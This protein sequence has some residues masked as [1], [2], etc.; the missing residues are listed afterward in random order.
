MGGWKLI[1]QAT[2]GE[3][4]K[5]RWTWH[6][7]TVWNNVGLWWKYCFWALDEHKVV[8]FCSSANFKLDCKK[9]YL[10]VEA[11][12]HF[13]VK[14]RCS[15]CLH[16]GHRLRHT[17]PSPLCPGMCRRETWMLKRAALCTHVKPYPELEWPGSW[18]MPKSSPT[19]HWSVFFG[20]IF[21]FPLLFLSRSQEN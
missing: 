17:A 15:H 1:S 20:D 7:H 4:V 10:K 14:F 13:N 11:S 16:A 8:A 6:A 3:R 2:G 9:L 12:K 5:K 18:A 19:P 21:D